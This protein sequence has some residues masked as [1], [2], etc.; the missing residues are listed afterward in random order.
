[1]KSQNVDIFKIKNIDLQTFYK[2]LAEQASLLVAFCIVKQGCF[3]NY[4]YLFFSISTDLQTQK[5]PCEH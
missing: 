5:K 4:E 3:T 2:Y 1:M